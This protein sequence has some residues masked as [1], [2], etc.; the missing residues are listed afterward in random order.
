[1]ILPTPT[2]MHSRH[3]EQVMR[4][5]KHVLVEI[6]MADSVEEAEAQV[7][8]AKETGVTAMGGH[9]RRF[10]PGHQCVH[11][12]VKAGELKIQQM[13]VQTYFFL[14]NNINAAGNLAELDRPSAVAPRRVHHRSVRVSV[15]REYFGLRANIGRSV[16]SVT[17]ASDTQMIK[18]TSLMRELLSKALDDGVPCLVGTASAD[19]RPQISPKGSIAVFDEETLCYWERSHRSSETRLTEN[20]KVVVYYRNPMRSAEIPYRAA[21]MRFHGTTRIAAAG[22]DREKAWNLTNVMEQEKDPTRTGV[23][24]LIRVD[25]VEELSGAVIMKRDD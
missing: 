1:V 15:R 21:A 20:P 6:P 4:A 18:L 11:K 5:S 24:V 22:P 13:D 25:L 10:N 9:V 12:K 14:R 19:G 7:K 23:A 16:S 17:V 3:G 8:N 2:K